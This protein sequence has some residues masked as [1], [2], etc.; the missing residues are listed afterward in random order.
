MW[1]VFWGALYLAFLGYCFWLIDEEFLK[2]R[3][4]ALLIV[5]GYLVFELISWYVGGHVSN[6]ERVWLGVRSAR[7]TD[8]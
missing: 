4:V 5:L 6:Y 8:L 7:L 1:A 3:E 2:M